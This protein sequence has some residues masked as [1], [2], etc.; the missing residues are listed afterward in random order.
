MSTHEATQGTDEAVQPVSEMSDDE[1]LEAFR[2]V[3]ISADDFGHADHVRLAWIILE[4]T[5]DFWDAV[6]E[7][8]TLLLRFV[9]H[10]D[11]REKYHETVTVAYM[12]LVNERR[13]RAEAPD[14]WDAFA[15]AHEDLLRW[16]DGPLWRYYDPSMLLD[17]VAKEHFVLPEPDPED[18]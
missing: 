3:R 2:A 10:L 14:T 16:H 18:G 8:R 9:D 6:G 15:R 13:L 4:R 5:D 11:E 1:F 17:P 7:F 12:A